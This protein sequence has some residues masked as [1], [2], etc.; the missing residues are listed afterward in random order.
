[1]L[2]IRI[3]LI[4]LGLF[5]IF[6]VGPAV[7]AAATVF[8]RREGT[9]FDT[10]CRQEQFAPAADTLRAARD[11]LMGLPHETAEIAAPDGVTLRGDYFDRGA[12][13]TVL[14]LHGYRAGAMLNCGVQAEAFA[15][16]GWNVLLVDQRAHGRSGGDHTLL[17]L[18]ERRDAAAWA[19][20]AA[21]RHGV[22]ALAIYGVSM[23]AAAVAYAS[24]ELDAGRVRALIIDC[25]FTSPYEQ[26]SG[27]CR[28][29][30]LP[31]P[32]LMPLIRLMARIFYGEDLAE[33]TKR[34]LART[35]IP[36]FFLHGTADLTVPYEQGQVNFEACASPKAF[37]TG[38]G[39]GHTMCFPAEPDR[40][41]KALFAFLS[42]YFS[43]TPEGEKE[44]R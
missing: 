25:G 19:D 44:T 42:P 24:D 35:T 30:H 18:R 2:I 37:F 17:G 15:R 29:R 34:H 43:T 22:K 16:R 26:M 14:L 23:G 10:A 38:E 4:L 6:L 7:V 39:A 3:L 11:A 27:D 12:D 9:D 41:E 5:V 13:R 31:T 32:L 20:W 21:K 1:M 8:A 33:D 36:A 40:A 28:R